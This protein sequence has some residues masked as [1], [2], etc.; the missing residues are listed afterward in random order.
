VKIRSWLEY[1]VEEKVPNAGI[2]WDLFSVLAC[3]SPKRQ[4]GKEKAD[5]TYS[6]KRI[7]YTQLD[8]DLMAAMTHE[9]PDVLYAE[10]VGGELGDPEDGFVAFP[11]YKNW[12]TGSESCKAK[13]TKELRQFCADV[14]GS[15]PK[16]DGYQGIAISLLA[17]V[18][19]QW[20]SLCSFIDS[21][22]IGLTGVA[23][24]PKEKA[25]KLTGRCVASLFTA[26]GSYRAKVSQLDDLSPLGN[27]SAC[28]WNVLQCHRIVRSFEDVDY[29]GHPGVVTTMNLFLLMERVDP[30]L[31]TANEDKIK[32]LKSEGKAANAEVKRLDERYKK[33]ERD[34][35]NLSIAV[36]GL[37]TKANKP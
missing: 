37:Q 10:K 8:N 34:F 1:L 3:M 29:R 22:Y 31:L 14:E 15:I 28:M 25:W 12:I 26:M 24:F 11:S 9:R 13:P 23:N 17:D 32:R 36:S 19:N 16:G 20:F 30:T 27:K 18:K 2:F 4:K 5:E 21:F 6:A 33:L 7:Q 35:T